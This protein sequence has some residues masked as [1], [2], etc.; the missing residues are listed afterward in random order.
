QLD[1]QDQ[2]LRLTATDL[3][4]HLTAT[5]PCEV[6]EPGTIVLPAGPLAHL[7]HRLPTATFTLTTD[8]AT[9]QAT[10]RYG[11]NKAVLNGFGSDTLPQFP[12]MPSDALTV[13][14]P[15]GTLSTLHRQLVFACAHDETRP[16][17]QGVSAQITAGRFLL[18]ATDG[19]RLSYTELPVPDYA[20][21][22]QSFII[23]PKVLIEGARLNTTQAITLT[24]DSGLIRVATPGLMLTSRLVD[25][26]YPDYQRVIPAEYAHQFRITR[27]DLQKSLERLQLMAT[28]DVS[29]VHLHL[30][31]GRLTL[32][33]QSSEVG[34]IEE[35]FDCPTQGQPLDVL[36]NPRYLL[37]A[38]K[39]LDGEEALIELSG[40]QSPA[41][42]RSVNDAPYFHI[43]LP[44]RQLA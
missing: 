7:I 21:A 39:S 2:T 33:L 29:P 40:P 8:A 3:S 35:T 44:L 6:S 42:I 19:S 28:K 16:V 32:S 12:A 38:M 4:H 14:L 18:A 43:A 41:R 20:G 34:H 31:P 9:G 22:D 11:R 30:A 24:L 27:A 17:L 36:F 15:A 23:P 13:S 25:G 1:A 37:D 26:Q 5:I 10:I